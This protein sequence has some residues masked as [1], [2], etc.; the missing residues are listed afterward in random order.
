MSGR[1]PDRIDARIDR[2]VERQRRQTEPGQTR[3]IKNYLMTERYDQVAAR[4]A[5][6]RPPQAPQSL[7]CS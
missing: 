6:D 2:V 4:N 5:Y 3:L 1:N 7:S